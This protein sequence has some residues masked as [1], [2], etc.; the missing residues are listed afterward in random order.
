[1]WLQLRAWWYTRGKEKSM[2][3]D[4]REY[5]IRRHMK[6]AIE[7]LKT[8]REREEF[9]SR[10]ME[11]ALGLDNDQISD[12]L[13]DELI[14]TAFELVGDKPAPPPPLPPEP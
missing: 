12:E 7:G 1:M 8:P 4:V 6:A 3:R 14:R 2:P 10:M 9:I 11:G 5:V 13:R